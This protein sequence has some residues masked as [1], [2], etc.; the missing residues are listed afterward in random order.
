MKYTTTAKLGLKKSAFAVNGIDYEPDDNKAYFTFTM[1][2]AWPHVNGNRMSFS[3][4]TLE[5]SHKTVQFNLIDHEHIA[6]G[7]DGIPLW[8]GSEVIGT[9]IDSY[10]EKS[11]ET[12]ALALKVVGVLW[13]RFEQSRKIIADIATGGKEWKISMEALYDMSDSGFM[14]GESFVYLDDADDKIIEAFDEGQSSYG[15]Q[16]LTLMLGGTG[17][18]GDLDKPNVNFWG[19]ALTLNPADS[20]AKIHSLVASKKK[21][22]SAFG[23]SDYRII[24][25]SNGDPESTIL[26][27]D[28]SQINELQTVEFFS[29][30]EYDERVGLYWSLLPEERDGVT[31]SQS[32]SFTG[33]LTNSIEEITMTIREQL[34]ALASDIQNMNAN[35]ESTPEEIEAVIT[36]R[37]ESAIS[38]FEGWVS[39][40]DF[41]T[42]VADAVEVRTSEDK[43]KASKDAERITLAEE[44]GIPMTASRKEK[45]SSFAI[46]ADEEVT[47]WI[48]TVSEDINGMVADLEEA[49]VSVT[50][51]VKASIAKLDGKDSDGYKA[52]KSAFAIAKDEPSLFIDMSDSDASHDSDSEG[53][54]PSGQM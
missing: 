1:L 20:D 16:P 33:S 41:D 28:G 10:L 18:D 15:N 23:A 12:G 31:R 7:N 6:E 26:Y 9:M 51:T 53:N 11:E 43:E 22:S 29:W 8:N 54:E 19:S 30:P 38:K 52:T 39:P 49:G 5:R 40:E 34:E 13:K 24:I 47:A 3:Q 46:D 44:A 4:K 36:E 14:V 32:F 50:D 48:D 2:H 42:A 45:L 17:E 27:L 37:V 25:A 21:P 35:D